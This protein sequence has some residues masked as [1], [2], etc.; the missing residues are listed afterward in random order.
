MLDT[1]LVYVAMLKVCQ[2]FAFKLLCLFTQYFDITSSQ[3]SYLI[4]IAIHKVSS[5]EDLL[6]LYKYGNY[7]GKNLTG[8][9]RVVHFNST[10]FIPCGSKDAVV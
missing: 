8:D 2:K 6:P 1:S 4:H 7:I 10:P 3:L 9:D 5:S